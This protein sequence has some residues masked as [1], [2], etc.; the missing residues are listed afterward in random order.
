M[1]GSEKNKLAGI[2]IGAEAS[3]FRVSAAANNTLANPVYGWSGSA[4]QYA[5][6]TASAD[7]LYFVSGGT[8]AIPESIRVTVPV[9]GN[10]DHVLQDMNYAGTI[11]RIT[12]VRL[13]GGSAPTATVT[14]KINSTAVT[15][16]SVAATTGYSGDSA[17]SALNTFAVRDVLALTIASWTGTPTHCELTVHVTKLV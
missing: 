2:A 17:A 5:A 4:A 13:I 11:T 15:G 16:I 3:V 12:D 7:T 14:I 8:V 9:T 10:A 1:L 6:L